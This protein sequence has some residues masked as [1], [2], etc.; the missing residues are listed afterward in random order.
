MLQPTKTYFIL[1]P[2]AESSCTIVGDSEKVDSKINSWPLKHDSNL[3]NFLTSLELIMIFT[4]LLLQRQ[5]TK[6]KNTLLILTLVLCLPERRTKVLFKKRLPSND[7][8][9]S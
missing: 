1:F 2:F 9:E 5:Y 4:L 8:P 6:K 7:T 3:Q